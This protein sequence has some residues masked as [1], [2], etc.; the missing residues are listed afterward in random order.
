MEVDS[1]SGRELAS[2]V[3]TN[4]GV[5]CGGRKEKMKRRGRVRDP[6]PFV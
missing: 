3:R 5:G 4:G 6:R 2:I 1:E